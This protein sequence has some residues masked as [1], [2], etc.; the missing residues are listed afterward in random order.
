MRATIDIPDSV[1]RELK[2]EAAQDGRTV[3][4]LVLEGLAARKNRA[5]T[6]PQKPFVVP[7]ISSQK[8]GSLQ[9]TNEQIDDLL[10]LP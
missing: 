2:M 9:L 1:Y 10:F 7:V 8:P 5:A 4:E 3:R 6:R